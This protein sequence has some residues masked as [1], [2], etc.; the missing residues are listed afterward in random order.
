MKIKTFLKFG[1]EED[2]R[3]LLENGTIFC[4]PIEYFRKFEDGHVRGDS[5]EGTFNVK[6]FSPDT[7]IQLTLQDGRK[8]NLK[9]RELH[10][11]EFYSNIKGNLYCLTAITDSDIDEKGTVVIDSKF[12]SFGSH[13][14]F[15]KD[16]K[17]FLDLLISGFERNKLKI[18]TGLV[19]YYDK[20]FFDGN[21]DL[22]MKPNEFEYQKEFRVF[23][24]N[25][26]LEPIK[27]QLGPL[28][29]IAE[30]IELS[31]PIEKK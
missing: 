11:R 20:K 19:K 13:F 29:D 17:K 26:K 18:K 3:D 10:L 30:M 6:N 2:T 12:S 8:I 5:Y 22:F 25:E 23:I 4:N 15:I 24:Q 21:L 14:L 1:S 31:Q 27:I 9:S 16:V 7:D 28:K